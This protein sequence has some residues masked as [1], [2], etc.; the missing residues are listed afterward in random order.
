[1]GQ[2]GRMVSAGDPGPAEIQELA[3]Q[4]LPSFPAGANERQQEE[5]TAPGAE[6]D[7]GP[8]RRAGSARI[9]GGAGA[10][11]Q[12]WQ[13]IFSL[14]TFRSAAIAAFSTFA[15]AFAAAPRAVAQSLVLKDGNII[16]A[17]E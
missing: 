9:Q 12:D 17:D 5:R 4:G 7:A 2:G 1:M 13:L 14:M 16:H 6:P 11:D 3:R 10:P 8:E 15:F